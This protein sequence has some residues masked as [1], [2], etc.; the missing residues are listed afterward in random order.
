MKKFKNEF[1]VTGD[2]V[3][4]NAF[5]EKL[6]S[7]GYKQNQIAIHQGDAIG[8]YNDG[9]FHHT[10]KFV[11]SH[12]GKEYKLPEQWAEALKLA[13][14][15]ENEKIK[16]FAG[17]DVKKKGDFVHIGCKK[18][19]KDS[20]III[21][22]IVKSEADD[23]GCSWDSDNDWYFNRSTEEGRVVFTVTDLDRLIALYD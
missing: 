19:T 14:E 3:L 8:I 13:E 7:I 6:L 16:K 10:G 5:K 23:R 9:G 11:V 4:I 2:P 1:H 17:W 20:L 22:D 15:H 18:F 12:V 21:R